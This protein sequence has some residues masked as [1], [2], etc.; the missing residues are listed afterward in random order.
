MPYQRN[1]VKW[2]S[3]GIFVPQLGEPPLM[4]A[5]GISLQAWDTTVEGRGT[6]IKRIEYVSTLTGEVRHVDEDLGNPDDLS[7][8]PCYFICGDRDP[9]TGQ[10]KSDNRVSWLVEAFENWKAHKR[11]AA[12]ESLSYDDPRDFAQEFHDALEVAKNVRR[13]RSQLYTVPA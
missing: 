12:W 1:W 2:G 6:R 8:G 3:A 4:D 9:L 13:K 11:D 5:P 10:I 7:W